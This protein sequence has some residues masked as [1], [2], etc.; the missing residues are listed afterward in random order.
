MTEKYP[1]FCL[2]NEIC[3]TIPKLKGPIVDWVREMIVRCLSSSPNGRPSFAEIFEI[4]KSH[5]YDIFNDTKG[6]N[7]TTHQQK[8]KEDI[9]KRILKIESFEYQHQN[10]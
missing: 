8:L 10:E 2:K 9:E 1:I 7:L 3:R 4:M 5:N 6:S